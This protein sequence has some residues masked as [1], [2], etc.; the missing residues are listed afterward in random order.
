MTTN[1]NTRQIRVSPQERSLSAEMARLIPDL[2]AGSAEYDWRADAR[3]GARMDDLMF[4]SAEL[5]TAARLEQVA[6]AKAECAV[7]PVRAKCLEWALESGQEWGVWGGLDED[8][9]AALSRRRRNP[10]PGASPV[11]EQLPE[12]A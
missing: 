5:G 2:D 6:R 8:E 7:C 12:V 10:G 3:C 11:I 1:T 4:P 9:R